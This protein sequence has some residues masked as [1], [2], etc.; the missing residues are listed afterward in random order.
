MHFLFTGGAF[1][2]TSTPSQS[3]IRP[4]ATFGNQL[5]TGFVGFQQ[6]PQQQQ[7]IFAQPQQQQ[8]QQQQMLF[9]Q[10]QLQQ[11]QQQ[12]QQQQ[13]NSEISNLCAAVTSCAVFGDDRDALLGRWNL[14]QASWGVGKAY[15]NASAPPVTLTSDN[16]L[17]RFKAVGYSALPK[18]DK[19]NYFF[20][21]KC[22]PL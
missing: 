2:F 5:N 20:Y 19:V 4:T 21:Y 15:Y 8:Q 9:Q 17:C 14:I 18:T 6:Q 16:P 12:P 11:L 13:Q 7:S 10:Q 22:G 3:L 1:S